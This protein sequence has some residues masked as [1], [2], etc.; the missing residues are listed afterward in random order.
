MSRSDRWKE[1]SNLF[2]GNER[3]CQARLRTSFPTCRCCCPSNSPFTLLARYFMILVCINRQLRLIRCVQY[4]L[5]YF[6]LDCSDLCTLCWLI[7][8][9]CYFL[10]CTDVCGYLVGVIAHL[11]VCGSE[12]QAVIVFTGLRLE[13]YIFSFCVCFG[14]TLSVS[15]CLPAFLVSLC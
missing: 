8:V 5:L 11:L 3:L 4:R 7:C 1:S 10:Y 12:F 15:I 14:H 2:L 9:V 6:L 13:T